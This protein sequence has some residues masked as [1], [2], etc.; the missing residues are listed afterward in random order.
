MDLSAFEKSVKMFPW[1]YD[2]IRANRKLFRELRDE[3]P[4]EV[5]RSTDKQQ[6]RRAHLGLQLL[7]CE[8]NACA[9]VKTVCPTLRPIDRAK[10]GRDPP[11]VGQNPSRR[12]P[13][14]MNAMSALSQ[15]LWMD[16]LAETVVGSRLPR[17]ALSLI[18]SY[19]TIAP[20]SLTFQQ[21]LFKNNR[22]YGR[23][24]KHVNDVGSLRGRVHLTDY[25]NLYA[26]HWRYRV[27]QRDRALSAGSSSSSDGEVTAIMYRGQR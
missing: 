15:A 5:R 3:T 6:Y 26:S 24:V 8:V 25:C 18:Y 20:F 16:L 23:V 21:L 27:D 7:M 14:E 12:R 17:D 22:H 11:P 19:T 13:G 10:L 2:S 1:C 4:G 9:L